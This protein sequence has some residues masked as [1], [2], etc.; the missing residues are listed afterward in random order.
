MPI[1]EY[2]CEECGYQEEYIENRSEDH[3]TKTC[4]KCSNK[5]L[6]RLPRSNFHL[7]GTGWYKTDYKS[8]EV[9]SKEKKKE[10]K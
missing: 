8:S 5:M 2:R 9:K 4:P 3:E 6:Y 1:Y 7:K 10:E